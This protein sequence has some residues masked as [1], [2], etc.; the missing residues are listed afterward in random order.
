MVARVY[1]PYTGTFTQPDPIIGGGATPYGYTDGDPVNEL[2][3]AGLAVWRCSNGL[4]VCHGT[5]T[6]HAVHAEVQSQYS[7]SEKSGAAICDEGV[8]CG[9]AGFWDG[10][11]M[12]AMVVPAGGELV[13]GV[14]VALAGTTKLTLLDSARVAVGR[15]A[16]KL[17]D[18]PAGRFLVNQT[19]R[20]GLNYDGAPGPGSIPGLL[21]NLVKRAHGL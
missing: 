11:A 20:T 6:T 18:S 2:D 16:L 1:D 9:H 14:K 17:G 13:D 21:L 4:S 8:H 19:V 15:V 5:L 10:L 3:L 7:S 12:A